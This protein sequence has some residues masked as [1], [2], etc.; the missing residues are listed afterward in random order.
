MFFNCVLSGADLG[1]ILPGAGG[2]FQLLDRASDSPSNDT[3]LRVILP[4][5]RQGYQRGDP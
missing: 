4:R 1:A 2:L 5:R 3:D